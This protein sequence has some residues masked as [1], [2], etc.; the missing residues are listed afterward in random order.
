MAK[1]LSPRKLLPVAEAVRLRVADLAGR[2][3]SHTADAAVAGELVQM[4]DVLKP[5]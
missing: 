5:R 2:D 3:L 1:P 4:L